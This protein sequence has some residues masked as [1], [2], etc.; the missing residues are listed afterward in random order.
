MTDI[1]KGC[2]LYSYCEVI[3]VYDTYTYKGLKL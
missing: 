3:F 1:Q 2:M